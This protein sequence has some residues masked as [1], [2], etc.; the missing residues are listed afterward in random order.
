MGSYEFKNVNNE[1]KILAS[2]DAIKNDD[3]DINVYPNPVSE[4]LSIK[5]TTFK[6]NSLLRLIDMSGKIVY[7]NKLTENGD[8]IIN[9]DVTSFTAGKYIVSIYSDKIVRSKQMIVK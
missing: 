6:D 1:K 5:C 7:E 4:T 9:I 3:F 8:V 2:V